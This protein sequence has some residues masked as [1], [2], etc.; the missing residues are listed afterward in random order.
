MPGVGASEGAVMHGRPS[1]VVTP[2]YL[3]SGFG[4]MM[5]SSTVAVNTARSSTPNAVLNAMN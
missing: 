1:V 2:D 3:P 5:R 4:M